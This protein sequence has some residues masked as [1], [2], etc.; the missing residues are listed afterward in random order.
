MTA[1]LDN[2][3]IFSFFFFAISFSADAIGA[4]AAAAEAP[5]GATAGEE[6][7]TGA[8]EEGLATGDGAVEVDSSSSSTIPPIFSAALAAARLAW[9][10]ASQIFA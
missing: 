9:A 2:R 3:T 8:S 6:D 7:S 10:W 5:A 4:A 1:Q